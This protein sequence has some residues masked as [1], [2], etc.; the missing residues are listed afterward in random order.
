MRRPIMDGCRR[1]LFF[2]LCLA[3]FTS[4]AVARPGGPAPAEP[5]FKRH[6]HEHAHQRIRPDERPP[7]VA[8][9]N[10]RRA[11]SLPA[12][13]RP[14]VACDPAAIGAASGDRL[15]TRVKSAA[16]D[17]LQTLFDVGGAPARQLFSESKMVTIAQ[18][19]TADARA[20]A[21][22]NSAQTLQLILFLRAGY[23]AQDRNP[24]VVGTYGTA[25]RDAI[26]P[27][28]DAFVANSHFQDVNDTHGAVLS[29][30]VT[31]IDSAKQT[32]SHLG[33][34]QGLLD[35]FDDAA[36]AS[37]SMRGA[38]SN[39]FFVLYNSHG[40]DDFVAAVR[41]DASLL[42]ALDSF[43]ARN[44]HLLG[45]DDQHLTVNAAREL[46]R[47]LQHPGT[48]RDRTRARVRALLDNH[49]KTGPTA[50]VWVSAAQMA[51]HFDVANCS[52]Y[53]ICGFRQALVQDVLG[54]TYECAPTLRLRVQQMSNIDLAVT[55]IVLSIRSL[56]FHARL[57]TTY[58]PVAGD[59]NAVLEMA[60]FDSSL[61]YQTYAG[62]MF[63]ISTNNGGIYLEGNPSAPGNQ[64]RA[65]LY[66]AEWV[67]PS[68]QVW[69]LEHEY[70]HYLDGRFD[71]QGDFGASTIQPTIWWIEGLAEYITRPTNHPDAVA[72]GTQKTFQLSQIL[73]NDYNSS[74]ERIYT[75]GY[76]AVRFMFDRHASQVGIFLGQFRAGD[77]AAY[78][79]SLDLL[80]TSYDAEFHQWLTCIATALDPLLCRNLGG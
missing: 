43:V 12:V 54:T 77:Y 69:N 29:E 7:D 19:L 18:A 34:L 41:R 30:F 1:H 57:G 80:G 46:A 40:D 14:L 24:D 53:G 6:G 49:S 79:Q 75:W 52:S 58:V 23:Y 68:F 8:P 5:L 21:G 35:R 38:T 63:G 61:D 73:R 59:N 26:R 20:Y 22:N 31:L 55:C 37:E 33:T 2:T 42:D 60:I 70:T 48:L 3:L 11:L 16:P 47:F 56:D 36:L 45:T 13:A 9:E 72:T 65:I 25:L 15:V 44:R 39:V 51:E 32:A 76:L 74:S 4:E 67:R 27:A 10:L 66:E 62:P 28:L 64:A 71:M 50:G 17:C 78:R